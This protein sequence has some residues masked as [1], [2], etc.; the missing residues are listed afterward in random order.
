MVVSE[1]TL[2]EKMKSISREAKLSKCYTNHSI[3]PT[4]V[5]IF[6]K[7]G[8]EARHIMAVSEH[9]NAASIWTKAKLTFAQRGRC[10]KP[11]LQ[12]ARSSLLLP[13]FLENEMLCLH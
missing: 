9:K 11:L 3:R 4:A 2:G 1:R 10:R 12:D 6:D 8:F 13:A 5:T 7:S